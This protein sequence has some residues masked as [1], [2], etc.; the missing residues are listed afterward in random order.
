MKEI[1][2]NAWNSEPEAGIL[3]QKARYGEN[4]RKQ[5][6]S[7]KKYWESVEAA[8]LGKDDTLKSEREQ[9]TETGK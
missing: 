4:V 3:R 9:Q 5:A 7:Q 2:K 6:S 1:L 8:A